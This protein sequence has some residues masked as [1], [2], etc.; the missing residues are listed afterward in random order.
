MVDVP[1]LDEVAGK[2]VVGRRD[3][4]RRDHR[5]LAQLLHERF[6]QPIDRVAQLR[7]HAGAQP[8]HD[9]GRREELVVRRDPRRRVRLQIGTAEPG[10]VATDELLRRDARVDHV[11]HPAGAVE[12]A[13]HV[14]HLGHAFDARPL[15]QLGDVGAAEVGAR[16]LEPRERRH[17]RRR[18][19]DEAQRQPARGVDRVADTVDARDVGELVRVGEDRGRAVREHRRRVPVRRQHRTLEVHV[20]VHE[21]RRDEPPRA[22]EDGR[23]VVARPRLVDARDQRADDAD[24]GGPQLTRRDV[25]H[26]ATR[27][28][29]VE[30]GATP[31]RRHC[32]RPN[33]PVDR[34]RLHRDTSN[35]LPPN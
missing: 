10:R 8:L 3:E 4:V 21:P 12:H 14:H 34:I 25:D 13:V 18:L 7:R 33:H 27:E 31:R 17:A 32:T 1:D 24:V 28:Q 30:R 9:V 19:P 20:Q 23:G 11:D 15:E 22:V 6:E 29:Q 16:E 35:R 5:Q 2:D 26:R